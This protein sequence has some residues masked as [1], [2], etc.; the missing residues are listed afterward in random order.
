MV[1]VR[2]HGETG[3]KMDTQVA[4]TSGSFD[5]NSTDSNTWEGDVADSSLVANEEDVGLGGI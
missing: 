5:E 1:H 4:H 3:V 2:F